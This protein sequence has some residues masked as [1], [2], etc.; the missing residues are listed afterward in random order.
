MNRRVILAEHFWRYVG[1]LTLGIRVLPRIFHVRKIAEP[2][3]VALTI[4]RENFVNRGAV[5][6][7][8]GSGIASVNSMDAKTPTGCFP[9][10]APDR[11]IFPSRSE[12]RRVGKE[13]VSTG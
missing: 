5:V 13:G 12:E 1:I 3:R 2:L 10:F 8:Q 9:Q 7:A 11:S 4:K 6:C